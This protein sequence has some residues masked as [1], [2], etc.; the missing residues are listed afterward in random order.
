MDAEG[1]YSLLLRFT[2]AIQVYVVCLR[3]ALLPLATQP[4]SATSSG[5]YVVFSSSRLRHKYAVA[6]DR[7]TSVEEN[8]AIVERL[9]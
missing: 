1:K 9:L 4:Q 3:L 7:R 8:V 5:A 2:A 6:G